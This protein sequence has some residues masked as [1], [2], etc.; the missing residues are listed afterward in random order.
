MSCKSLAVLGVILA[1]FCMGSMARGADEGLIANFPLGEGTGTVLHD[2]TGGGLAGTIHNAEWV[3]WG[4]GSGLKFGR[5]DSYVELGAGLKEKTTGDMTLLAW[6]KLTAWP[7]PDNQT[8]W[9]IADCE[10]YLKSG[11]TLRVAGN[12]QRVYF[13][14]SQEGR[15]EDG[16]GGMRLDNNESYLVTLVKQGGTATIYLDGLLDTKFSVQDPAPPSAPLRI[17]GGGQSFNGL[18]GNFRLYNRALSQAEVLDQYRQGAAAHGKKAV[19]AGALG[20]KPYLCFDEGFAQL[21]VDYRGV[22]PAEKEDRVVAE[23]REDGQPTTL[24]KVDPALPASGFG[25]YLV[26][27]GELQPGR[28]EI[29]VTVRN[30]RGDKAVGTY[31]FS[32]PLPPAVAPAPR[33]RTV[34]AL[35]KPRPAPQ[36]DLALRPGG[37]LSLTCGGQS[38]S[39]DSDFSY[40]Q[41]GENAFFCAAAAPA[42]MEPRWSAVTHKVNDNTWEV[43]AEAGTYRVERRVAREASR[44]LVD[45]T[46]VNKTAA[47]LGVIVNHRIGTQGH[48]FKRAYLAGY[49]TDG[50]NTLGADQTA[51]LKTNPT[52]FL[53]NNDLGVGLVALDDVFIVQSQGALNAGGARLYTN[54]FAL[55]AGASYT[56]EW[57]IYPDAGG[58]YD[59]IN[60]VRRDEGRNFV[61]VDGGLAI[62]PVDEQRDRRWVP[63][64]EYL[65]LRNLRYI[66]INGLDHIADD[67]EL[68][69]DGID[70]L[71]YPKE[72]ALLKEQIAASHKVDPRLQVIFHIAHSLITTNKPAEVFPDSRVM[73]PDGKQATYWLGNEG[74]YLSERRKKEGWHWYIYYPTLENSFGKEMMRSVDVMADELGCNGAFMDGFNYAYGSEVTTDRWDGHTAQIDPRTKTIVRPLGS[75]FLLSQPTLVAFARKWREKGGIVIS[76][77]SIVTRTLGRE[78]FIHER[79]MQHGPDMHLAPTPV[80]LGDATA[81]RNGHPLDFYRDVLDKLE[82]GSLYF[83]YGEWT[84]TY[85]SVPAFMYPITVQEIG[86]G[87]VKGKERLITRHSGVYGWEGDRALHQAYRFDD[88]GHLA[89]H[90]FF[91]TV[92]GQSVRTQVQ[93]DRDEV[94]VIRRIP[95]SITSAAPVNVIVQQYDAGGLVLS[96]NGVGHVRVTVTD[97]DFAVKPGAKFILKTNAEQTLTAQAG[98]LSFDLDLNGARAVLLAAGH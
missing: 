78:Y 34:A 77:N 74:S 33:E 36:F 90:E 13:R 57:A 53:E 8:N 19:A 97:G 14:C 17:S 49:P 12:N 83:Y 35:P 18:I 31:A 7:Y 80:T 30:P 47:P 76:N 96:L 66:D 56:L 87:L 85:P 75:V 64:K 45:D 62:L 21:D 1:A 50:Q 51:S 3:K 6:V 40:P 25:E 71:W 29:R 23:L 24:L 27:L 58:Y 15:C 63:T 72:M 16:Q 69:I 67:P 44:V 65:T 32:Y 10:E 26:R 81:I 37:G 2:A 68:T 4:N 60:Q 79:E 20:L 11:W 84:L 73:L 92:D 98:G 46:F 95:V 38:Y 43:R 52:I 59:F 89:P 42:G 70:F 88:Q 5:T 28:C 48:E 39:V 91:T 93:L 22:M 82:W 86:N 41:G 55:D 94:A 54:S 61:T 9:V